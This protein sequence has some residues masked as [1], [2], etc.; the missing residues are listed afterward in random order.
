[1]TDDRP[2]HSPRAVVQPVG[3]AEERGGSRTVVAIVRCGKL[4]TYR[5]NPPIV[6]PVRPV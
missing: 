1:M 6:A 5:V 2:R 4:C 3:S